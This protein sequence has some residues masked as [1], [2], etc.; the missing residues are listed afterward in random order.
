MNY[1]CVVTSCDLLSGFD[2]GRQRD[3]SA[4]SH[5]ATPNPLPRVGLAAEDGA[6]FMMCDIHGQ[7][8]MAKKGGR[9]AIR[10]SQLVRTPRSAKGL[11]AATTTRPCRI[12]K[13][14]PV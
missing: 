7:T 4:D 9:V 12:K 11:P 14:I 5:A 6:S 8:M 1:G 10:T 3:R 13:F 2:G